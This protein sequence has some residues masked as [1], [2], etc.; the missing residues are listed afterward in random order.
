MNFLDFVLC[1]YIFF[2]ES[3]LCESF[4]SIFCVTMMNLSFVKKLCREFYNFTLD[5]IIFFTNEK[6]FFVLFRLFLA[7]DNVHLQQLEF[8]L[9][10]SL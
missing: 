6:T 5:D 4:E 7:H 10:F 8:D 1:E 2:C 9:V 3:I